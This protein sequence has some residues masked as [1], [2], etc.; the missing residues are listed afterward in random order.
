MQRHAR[1]GSGKRISEI[2]RSGRS[3]ANDLLVVRLLPNG[4]DHNRYC[5]VAGKRVGNAV[6]RNR[7][8]RR[9]RELVRS[10]YVDPGWDVVFIAR[11]RA[12]ESTFGR[13]EKSVNNLLRR[14]S[15]ASNGATP[16]SGT[17]GRVQP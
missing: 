16:G 10:S 3:A 13:L 17:A 14:T 6:A 12:G 9:L 4:R 15:L 1:L 7:V 8:K 2:H 11:S 5:F